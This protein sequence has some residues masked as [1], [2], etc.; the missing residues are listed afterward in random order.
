MADLFCR[1]C[2]KCYIS[3]SAAYR[4]HER[5][6]QNLIINMY[7]KA[8]V[9]PL[10]HEFSHATSG[11]VE[12]CIRDQCCREIT[13]ILILKIAYMYEEPQLITWYYYIIHAYQNNIQFH[14]CSLISCNHTYIQ[15]KV[16]GIVPPLQTQQLCQ[17]YTRSKAKIFM[18][19][20][21]RN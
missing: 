21:S 15:C 12:K 19:M 20:H 1:H 13:L 16:N 6:K 4:L 17:F 8:S 10:L 3:I 18:G 14:C 2:E 7:E 5:Q 9:A 11:G